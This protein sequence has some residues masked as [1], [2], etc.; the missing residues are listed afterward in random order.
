MR[1]DALVSLN[2][3]RAVPMIDPEVNLAAQA[4]GV[5]WMRWI[6]PS[7]DSTPL[8][9]FRRPSAQPLLVRADSP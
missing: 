4:D 1:V 7:P 6:E 3:R 5:H 9:A 8:P 2:G